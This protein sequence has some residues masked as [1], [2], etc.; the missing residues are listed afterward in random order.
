MRTALNRLL[1]I[2]ATLAIGA[3]GAPT[4][5][6]QDV[7]TIAPTGGADEAE[8]FKTVCSIALKDLDAGVSIYIEEGWQVVNC[9]PWVNPNDDGPAP[10]IGHCCYLSR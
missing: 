9:S 4:A 8:F 5:V 6:A 2:F 7:T 1:P 10:I 3:C